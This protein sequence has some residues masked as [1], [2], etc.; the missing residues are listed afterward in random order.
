MSARVLMIALDGADGR[1][2]DTWSSDGA[3]PHLAALRRE[4]AVTHMTAPAATTDDAL[5]ASFQYA[6]GPGEHGRHHYL[7]RLSS[8]EMGMAFEDETG[9]ETFWSRLS[10][11]GRRVAVLDVPKCARPQ[12]INGLHLADWLAHGRYFH[13]PLSQPPELAD[14]VVARFG[15]APPSTC[16]HE[17]PALPDSE[18][19]E[20]T[21]R[22]LAS[23]AQ[24][25]AM[26]V[27]YLAAEPWDLFVI[28]FKEAHCASHALWDLTEPQ[29]AERNARLGEPLKAILAQIDAAVGDLVAAAGPGAAVIVFSTTEMEPNSTLAHLGSNL[30]ARLNRRLE[31]IG[32]RL[33]RRWRGAVSPPCELLPYNENALALRVRAEFRDCAEAM[34]RDLIDP[35]TGAPAVTAVD[36]PSA[37]QFGARA[38]NLPDLLVR[39]TA[40]SAPRQVISARLGRIEAAP[41]PMRP[42]NHAPGG[43]VVA[44][45]AAAAQVAAVSGMQDLGPLAVRLLGEA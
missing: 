17:T 11:A 14:E 5:W 2:L 44:A 36:R 39:G 20:V 23:V 31:S 29:A 16:Y 13:A 34:L 3:L 6:C 7:Q 35:T 37:E 45:G 4:G 25:R 10:A 15:P 1:Q 8:G 41:P 22:L 30:V 28:G 18:A 21:G 40:G 42:G 43:F 19:L 24:K 26:G 33:M 38:A 9:R 27:S 12:P 32:D